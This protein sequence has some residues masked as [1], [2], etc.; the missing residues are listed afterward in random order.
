[1]RPYDLIS[2]IVGIGVYFLER[3]QSPRAAPVASDCLALIVERLAELASHSSAGTTWL[4]NPG[5][6]PEWQRAVAPNGYYNL[7]VAHGVPG[8]I[9]LLGQVCRANIG[10]PRARQLLARSIDW[11]F[12]RSHTGAG[13]RFPYWLLDG[14]DRGRGEPVRV[15]WCY[16]DLGISAALLCA[17]RCVG[18]PRWEQR[19][20]ELA[21]NAAPRRGAAAMARDATLCHGTAGIAHIFNRLFQAT[22]DATF[23][24]AARY[25]L[26][27]TLGM[28]H[29]NAG[30]AG[31]RALG[32]PDQGQ[33]ATW[34]D[35]LG[36][37]EG[38]TGIGLALLA[39]T[40]DVE[41]T[42]DRLLLISET[43]R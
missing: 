12:A 2:G 1:V 27:R 31:Y 6:L 17:A 21:R 38:A 24:E 18:D 20:L 36:F 10:G 37:L 28:R 26:E 23:E 41:P 22:G 5:H 29:A 30:I 15:A 35:A 9:A 32:S 11:L 16:G 8:V 3:L 43:P 4:T 42:W 14:G 25:W 19:A 7:G 40:S 13:S 33:P 34:V 39:A